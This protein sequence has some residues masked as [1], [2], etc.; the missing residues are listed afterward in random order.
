MPVACYSGVLCWCVQWESGGGMRQFAPTSSGNYTSTHASHLAHSHHLYLYLDPPSRLC[1]RPER[2][3]GGAVCGEISVE[4]ADVPT[5]SHFRLQL[6]LRAHLRTIRLL[7]SSVPSQACAV[8]I[9]GLR[10]FAIRS[11]R[12]IGSDQIQRASCCRR[13]P[14]LLWALANMSLHLP[15]DA[16]SV[17]EQFM[18]DGR[19]WW[20]R[21]LAIT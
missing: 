13:R 8:L 3:A 1:G 11:A 21:L 20:A 7:L 2:G 19:S 10:H 17:L 9:P 15:E 5:S 6:S 18:H 12:E 14:L 16:A 4:L